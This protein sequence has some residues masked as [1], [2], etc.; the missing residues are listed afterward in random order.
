M[1]FKKAEERDVVCK[2]LNMFL[3]IVTDSNVFDFYF[4]YKINITHIKKIA[5][6]IKN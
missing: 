5:F 3:T 2:E 1:K 6:Q 4:I